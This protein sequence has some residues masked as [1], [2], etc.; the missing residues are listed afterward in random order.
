MCVYG[1][2]VAGLTTGVALSPCLNPLSGSNL[3]LE[4]NNNMILSVTKDNVASL[5]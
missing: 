4:D 3:T 2:V 5:I 1:I